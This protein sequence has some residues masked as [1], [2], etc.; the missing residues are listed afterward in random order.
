[1]FKIGFCF[2]KHDFYNNNIII[3]DY[4]FIIDFFYLDFKFIILK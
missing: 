2:L 4:L 3:Y 1:M